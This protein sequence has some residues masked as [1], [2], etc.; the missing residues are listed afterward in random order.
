[1]MAPPPSLASAPVTSF[2]AY[3]ALMYSRPRGGG[4]NRALMYSHPRW[5]P[6]T[7]AV[8]LAIAA[9]NA[10]MS[11]SEVSKLHIQRTSFFEASQS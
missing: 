6:H 8:S 4:R 7:P 10:S 5:G 11:S 9:M 3:R 1:M 2:S